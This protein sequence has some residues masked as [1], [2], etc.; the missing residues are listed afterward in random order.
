MHKIDELEKKWYH[1]KLKRFM[2]PMMGLMLTTAVI[3]GGYYAYAVKKINFFEH[4]SQPI[5]KV[6]ATTKENNQSQSKIV[7]AK[8]VEKVE[9]REKEQE[10]KLTLRD[11]SL[12][13]II[14]VIDMEKEEAIKYTQ[15]RTYHKKRQ[16]SLVKAK[17]NNY[18]TAKELARMAKVEKV[19]SQK[20]HVM[21]KMAFQST[22]VNYIETMKKKFSRSKNSRDA[23][24]LAKAFY[25][26]GAFKEAEEWALRANKINA[27]LDESW[28]LFAKSKAKLGKKQ[29]AVNILAKYYKQNKSSKV[30]ALLG[31]IKTGRI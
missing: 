16:S 3:G 20:P 25:K 15:K 10:K 6:L 23:L 18:L 19:Q 28:L 26:K 17:S 29:E 30:K 27:H 22:S 13:P 7:V 2:R 21:K 14:P 9:K 11:I 8:V 12:E 5:A 24:L 31:Q 1:Y 4:S